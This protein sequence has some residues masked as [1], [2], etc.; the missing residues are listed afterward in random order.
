MIF[1]PSWYKPVQ[2]TYDLSD[3]KESQILQVARD[4]FSQDVSWSNKKGGKK[5]EGGG[6]KHHPSK[7][8][9]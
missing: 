2:F 4:S 9:I 1:N 3:I 5:M 7:F 8:I 6:E